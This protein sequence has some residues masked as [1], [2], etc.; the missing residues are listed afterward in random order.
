MSEETTTLIEPI[1]DDKNEISIGAVIDDND[2]E[3]G[4]VPVILS[5]SRKKLES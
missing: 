1:F 5:N 3:G 4:I 2:D